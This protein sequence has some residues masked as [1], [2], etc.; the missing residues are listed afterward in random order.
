MINFGLPMDLWSGETS[1][2]LCPVWSLSMSCF[3]TSSQTFPCLSH[4]CSIRAPHPSVG[5]VGRRAYPMRGR[6][7]P[8]LHG[9]KGW[10]GD[11]GGQPTRRRKINQ[12]HSNLHGGIR[13]FLQ[14]H[15]FTTAAQ[16]KPVT[17]NRL[18]GSRTLLWKDVSFSNEFPPIRPPRGHPEPHGPGDAAWATASPT[19]SVRFCSGMG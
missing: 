14:T 13:S 10:D 11:P 18:K 1:A 16:Q 15:I 3:Q 8:Q 17:L 6:T 4:C 7:G 9:G 12:P 19:P 2:P 5:A